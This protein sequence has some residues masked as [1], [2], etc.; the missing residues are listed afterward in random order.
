MKRG[1]LAELR[2]LA[3][4]GRKFR[5]QQRGRQPGVLA[6]HVRETVARIRPAS[7]D[8][9]LLEFE[10][11]AVRNRTLGGGPILRVNREWETVLYLAK[12]VEREA[13]FKRLRNLAQIRKSRLAISREM[14]A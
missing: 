4:I 1:E 9:L 10:Y 14:R 8:D 3:E 11:Q 6:R 12:G 2:A 7:F 5:N 13:T